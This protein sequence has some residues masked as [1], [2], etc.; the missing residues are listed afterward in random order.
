MPLTEREKTRYD[1]Q[2]MIF[3]EDGQER[4]KNAYVAVVG[5]GGLGSPIALY[6]TAAG[7]GRLLLI[8]YQKPELSNLN[9]QVLHWE[10]D[11]DAEKSKAISAKE[12]LQKLNPDIDIRTFTEKLTPENIDT[13]LKGVDIVVDALDNYEVRYL[14]NEFCVR[15]R[16]PFIHGAVEGLIGQVTT[17]IPGETPCLKCLVPS[18]PKKAEKFPILGVTAGVVGLLEASEV[19]KLLTGH[20]DLLKGKLLLVDLHTDDFQKITIHKNPECSVCGKI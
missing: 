18:A 19:I 4:L 13:V 14:I 10:P 3:G 15:N 7:I 9:R 16:I 5:V 2:I 6:L 12:K 20:G 11:I 1:R 17:I 8:D